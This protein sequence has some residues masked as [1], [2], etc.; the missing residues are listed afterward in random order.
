MSRGFEPT[1]THS[2]HHLQ[3]PRLDSAVRNYLPNERAALARE[4]ENPE[5]AFR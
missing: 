3:D 5:I 4:V 2:L 1:I